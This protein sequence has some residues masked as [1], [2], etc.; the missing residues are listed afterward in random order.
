MSRPI[1]I[2]KETPF[3]ISEVFFSRTDKKGIIQ[4][5]NLTFAKISEYSGEELT[6]SAHNLIR[7]PDI[8]RAVFKLFWD[9]IK[10][11]RPIG[12]Y[13]KNMSQSGSYYWVFALALPIQEGYISLRLKPTSAIFQKIPSLYASMLEAE[14][15]A[16][17]D[18]AT[19]VLMSAL[20]SLG[21]DSYPAF[22][23][24]ALN[25]ELQ[26]RDA[27]L[28][29]VKP[30][31]SSRDA[32]AGAK[33][34]DR[35]QNSARFA[36][37]EL[38]GSAKQVIEIRSQARVIIRSFNDL[39]KLSINMAAASEQ[40][41]AAGLSLSQVTIGFAEVAHDIQKQI[42]N[43]EGRVS[44]LLDSLRE[45][46]FDL[47]SSRLQAEMITTFMKEEAS[48]DANASRYED[49]RILLAITNASVERALARVSG[50]RRLFDTFVRMVDELLK[51]VNGLELIRITGKIEVAKLG[52]G[53]GAAFQTHIDQM[54]AFL[55]TISAPMRICANASYAGL[56]A[57]RTSLEALSILQRHLVDVKIPAKK[58]A[59][60]VSQ[61]V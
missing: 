11:D 22:M 58:T 50:L 30:N 13:V 44:T 56:E 17:M 6:G 40:A 38:T 21:F 12:A 47:G 61:A 55:K 60:G 41:G 46:Q 4:S 5:Y 27:L 52:G 2:A 33:A 10:S 35:A 29:L 26:G 51:S 14:K 25:L 34:E 48:A 43:F 16:G 54:G 7:H 49:L 32:H 53:H 31:G 36:F 37:L 8:P 15:S 57:T 1:P 3:D 9:T 59:K 45:S 19:E 39:N 18:A 42:K 23:T 28:G 20:H 24:E